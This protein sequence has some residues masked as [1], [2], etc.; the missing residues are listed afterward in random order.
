MTKAI[1]PQELF[2]SLEKDEPFR[3]I[4]VRR[5]D[6]FVTGHIAKSTLI[7]L[8]TYQINPILIGNDV[9]PTVFICRSGR[10]SEAALNLFLSQFPESKAYNLIGGILAWNEAGLPLV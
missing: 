3:L 9:R 2:A 10:R 8:D 6:E 7:T 4:D 1:T 5:N